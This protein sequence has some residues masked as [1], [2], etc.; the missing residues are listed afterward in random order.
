MNKKSGALLTL[1]CA[2]FCA[3]VGA[4]VF[5]QDAY[6]VKPIRLVVPYAPGGP[7]D[8]MARLLGQKWMERWG[9]PVIVD[10]RAGGN[11]VIGAEYVARAP[12]DGYTLLLGNTSVLTINPA[13]YAKLPYDA[14]K[15]FAPVTL[16]VAAPLILVVHP[17]LSV[18][19]VVQLIA[20]AKSKVRA[21]TLTYASA[22]TGGVANMSG[23]LLKF[24]AKIDMVHVPYKGAGPAVTDLVS[25]QVAMTFTSTVSV[26]PLVKSGRL[27]GLAVSTAKRAP[28]LPD[29]PA[30]AETVPGYDVSPWYGVLAPAGTPAG[31]IQKLYAETV[32]IVAAPDVA[33]RLSLDGG[34]VVNSTPE[35]FARVLRE[36]RTKWSRVVKAAGIRVE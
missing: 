35:E 21:A 23:E 12:A 25:G 10:N 4:D 5:A 36:E 6:P 27:R 29:I 13:V 16:S 22:G 2:N 33:Q 28:S 26:M 9:P 3:N 15:Q 8:V 20:L 34:S 1:I 32:R 7:T 14:D 17:S 31:V 19:N 24:M 11:G 18:N 30:I